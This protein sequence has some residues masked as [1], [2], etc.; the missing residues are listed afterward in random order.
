M[1]EKLAEL[2]EERQNMPGGGAARGGR[3]RRTG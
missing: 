3:M 2:F 1:T